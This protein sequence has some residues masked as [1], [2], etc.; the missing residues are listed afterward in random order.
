MKLF[1]HIQYH[2]T[3]GEY[4]CAIINN[5]KNSTVQLST[6]NGYDWSGDIEYTFDNNE[7]FITY[8]YA[9]FQDKSCKRKEIGLIPHILCRESIQQV[10]SICH[11]SWRDLPQEVYRYSSAFCDIQPPTPPILKND[12]PKPFITLRAICPGVSERGCIL[13]LSGN[14]ERLGN[15]EYYAPVRMNKSHSNAWYVTID[16]TVLPNEFEYKFVTINPK[17]GMITDWEQGNNRKISLP[18]ISNGETLYLPEAE[19]F[20]NLPRPRIAG[21]AIPVFSLRSEGSCGSGDFGDLKVLIEWAS[22]TGQRVIQ[23]LP[24]NDTTMSGKWTDSYPYSSISIYAFHPMYIDLR[25][26]PKLNNEK[27]LLRFEK[28]RIKVNALAKMDYE[29]TNR[30]KNAYL[31]AVFKQ[32]KE[33]ILSSEE[34]KEFFQN[35]K[36]WLVPYA[37]FCYL[38]DKYKTPDFSLWGKYAT[39]NAQDIEKL[40][41]PQNKSYNA[42]SYFYFVQYELHLQ[43]L[44]VSRHARKL[45][46]ILKGDIPIGISRTSVEAW[47]E[48]YYFNMNGQ[49]GAPP[50]AF[51]T[52]GQNWGMPTYNWE[53]MEKDNYRWWEQ[54]LRKM[55]EYF[56][57]YRIDHIL[58]FFRI[59][60]IPF[61]SIQGLLGQFSPSL[62]MS[63][64]ELRSF[65][66]DF[67]E[68]MTQPFINDTV[69]EK[70]FGE[71]A[72]SI[73]QTFLQPTADRRYNLREEFNTQRKI[74]TYF[75]S[76]QGEQDKHIKEGLFH[77]INNVLF[78]HDH[79]QPDLLHPRIAA[80]YNLAFSFL[81]KQQ[82]EAFNLLHE[83]FYYH[84]HNEFWYT[85]AMKKLPIL[86]Q[87]TPMLACGEDL[88]MVPE[89]VPWVMKQLQILSLE[90]QR[91]PKTYGEEFG[92][93]SHYPFN[94]VCSIGTHDMSTLRGWWKENPQTT[95]HFYR[96]VLEHTD[97]VPGEA[98]GSICEE[99]IRMH[100]QSTSML[101]I[102]TWQDWL[103]MDEQ[104]RNADIDSERINIPSNPNHYWC[105]RMHIT[106]EQLRKESGLN[107]KIRQLIKDAGRAQTN[108]TN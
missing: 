33:N 41:N 91:M 18:S 106:I 52:N 89:C 93:P 62:P 59:W 35:N 56:T 103:S 8:R 73:K 83:H 94:S 40:C 28:E 57:A 23:I 15:W 16:T 82:Q 77:L 80:Q 90:I 44:E 74:E 50:D 13:G 61:H 58:G 21:T 81:D 14:C 37:A 104:L 25:Q 1:F 86:T 20:F 67:N 69:L 88:G 55:S 49:A 70:I 3:W 26:L 60:E 53:M 87:S 84:R 75:N 54:R 45:G 68:S 76:K 2:T 24:I 101:C 39:Y 42:I 96:N 11:D 85:N 31:K 10:Q 47:T 100:L 92:N 95:R 6:R 19:V 9:V 71:K 48:P 17:T 51:S 63:K 105:W 97:N 34:F 78:V 27:E 99:V 5:N 38:R 79:K 98:T 65:G 30:I 22:E 36:S 43:L 66:F 4:L 102:L 108:E 72:D 64:E 7:T 107:K 29:K 12:Y 46:I 32:E